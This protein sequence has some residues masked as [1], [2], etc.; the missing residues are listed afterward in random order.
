MGNSPNTLEE[1]SIHLTEYWKTPIL[2]KNTHVLIKPNEIMKNNKNNSFPMCFNTKTTVPMKNT[3][4]NN[5]NTSTQPTSIPISSFQHSENKKNILNN[6]SI[7]N[8]INTVTLSHNKLY[9]HTKIYDQS[10]L[11]ITSDITQTV[12]RF[13]LAFLAEKV[14]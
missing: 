3:N 5:N 11:W 1:W 4:K 7:N 12:L 6:T 9:L 8:S 14:K 13:A 10:N 2:H